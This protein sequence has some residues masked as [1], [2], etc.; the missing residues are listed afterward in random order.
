[1]AVLKARHLAS[2]ERDWISLTFFYL[3][4]ECYLKHFMTCNFCCRVVTSVFVNVSHLNPSLKCVR[5]AGAHLTEAC[6]RT[7]P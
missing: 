1:M 4:R 5:Q 3:I 2:K 6:F 7:P